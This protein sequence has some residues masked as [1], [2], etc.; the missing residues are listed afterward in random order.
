MD[1]FVARKAVLADL[2]AE[3][4]LVETKK[5][6]LQ[7]PIS[8]RSDAVIEPMLTDQWFLDLTS[9]TRVDG[10]PGPGGRKAITEPALDAVPPAPSSSCRKTG[11]R[12]TTS[13]SR[14]SRTGASAAS[15]GG[16]IAFRRGTTKPATS[17]SARMKPTRLHT[18]RPSRSAR[19]ARTTTCSTPGS[20]PHSGRSRRS[21][22]PAKRRSA[23]PS[24]KTST[25]SCRR[26]CSSPAST[27]SSSGS[28][29]WSWRPCTSPSACRFARS[30]STRSCAT[31]KARRCRSRRATRSIRWT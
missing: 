27:S 14:T 11:R 19:F 18:R 3:G 12:R 16:A 26:A 15:S 30:T 4:L 22:G 2:E 28:R 6:K 20:R 5:H 31:P 23:R 10:K 1:R 21:A 9:D 13:G 25:C 17:S 7:V 29:A 24:G 8:Q